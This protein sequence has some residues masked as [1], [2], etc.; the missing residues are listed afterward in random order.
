[1]FNPGNPTNVCNKQPQPF[2]EEM[3]RAGVNV[4][5]VININDFDTAAFNQKYTKSFQVILP[6]NFQQLLLDNDWAH[7]SKTLR[8][9]RALQCETLPGLIA[10]AR[11]RRQAEE[12]KI[13]HE[14]DIPMCVRTAAEVV[15]QPYLPDC[16]REKCVRKEPTITIPLVITIYT[17]VESEIYQDDGCTKGNEAKMAQFKASLKNSQLVAESKFTQCEAARKQKLEQLRATNEYVKT[18]LAGIDEEISIASAKLRN[19]QGI[20]SG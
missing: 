12:G 17:C 10:D 13:Q 2:I 4:R 9:H 18:Q 6:S 14:S 20:I 19:C 5:E 15:P 11:Q 8:D 3:R 1:M 16:S 7:V